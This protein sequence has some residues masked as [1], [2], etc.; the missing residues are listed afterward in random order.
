MKA[1]MN[2]I[3]L[4]GALIM[5]VTTAVQAHADC[6]LVVE[7][8]KKQIR[9]KIKQELFDQK[10]S[11]IKDMVYGERGMIQKQPPLIYK[12][13]RWPF[14]TQFYEQRDFFQFDFQ[15]SGAWNAS[16]CESKNDLASFALG[17]ECIT[18][19]DVLLVS[20]LAKQGKL[21]AINSSPMSSGTADV[22]VLTA[23]AE[24]RLDFD[25][26]T[27]QVAGLFGFARHFA[28]GHLSMNVQFPL[29][30]R[31]N[32]LC[33]TNDLTADVRD[34]MLANP[35]S[36]FSSMSLH[37]FLNA[38]LTD[39][40]LTFPSNAK[41]FGLGDMVSSMYYQ[42]P[43]KVVE[44]CILGLK[45]VLPTSRCCGAD[46]IWS[47]EIGNGGFIQLGGFF[48]VLYGNS[49][50][51]NLHMHAGVTGSFAANVCRRAPQCI[52]VNSDDACSCSP[53]LN[54][55]LTFSEN[56]T[57]VP[58]QSF[59]ELET[60]L[61][62]FAHDTFSFCL[63][64][65]VE[66]VIQVGNMF[67]RFFVRRGFLDIFYNFRIKAK[68]SI[69]SHCGDKPFNASGWAKKTNQLEH[70]IGGEWSY[71]FSNKTRFSFGS[72]YIFAGKNVPQTLEGHLILNVEF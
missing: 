31:E 51:V 4:I 30:V 45:L 62:A 63:T 47:P 21:Q 33:L 71:Q 64:P 41:E 1:M 43:T 70:K 12:L 29:L 22:A 53:M 60:C 69:G 19:Q 2:K 24:Q 50:W 9:D 59:A 56:L 55:A 18:V 52:S 67:E 38:F 39:N 54:D 34:V 65:G 42:I 66:G 15:V 13:P 25:A 28:R 16:C 35:N 11:I 17:K 6:K 3:F 20:K 44:R 68:D 7:L 36:R 32:N 48:S 27:W 49:R 10:R 46:L 40:N 72:S 23:L 37:E 14:Y 26:S 5:G 58:G 8:G 57:V 61:P